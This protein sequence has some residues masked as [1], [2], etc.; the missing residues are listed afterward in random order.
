MSDE[1]PQDHLSEEHL[2]LARILERKRSASARS[3]V[4][5][6]LESGL[7][8][9]ETLRRIAEVDRKHVHP[10]RTS[11]PPTTTPKRSIDADAIGAVA[12]SRLG[13]PVYSQPDREA[14]RELQ[15]R[16]VR[17]K[18]SPNIGSFWDYLF[19]QSRT[20]R[21]FNRRTHLLKFGLFSLRPRIDPAAPARYRRFADTEIRELQRIVEPILAD[22]W[23]VLT[24]AE[25]NLIVVLGH[26]CAGLGR[27]S[28]P[29]PTGSRRSVLHEYA[30]IERDLLL[31]IHE[32]RDGSRMRSILD[33]YADAQVG[34]DVPNLRRAG[35]TITSILDTGSST[36]GVAALVLALNMVATGRYLDLSAITGTEGTELIPSDY[37]DC[38]VETGRRISAYLERMIG[39]V[40]LLTTRL[41][42]LRR[43]ET[44]VR[45]RNGESDE[46]EPIKAFA[47][48]TETEKN[49]LERV[50]QLSRRFG[51]YAGPILDG[52]TVVEGGSPVTAFSPECFGT[53]LDRINRVARRLEKARYEL[54]SFSLERFRRIHRQSERGTTFEREAVERIEEFASQMVRIGTKAA[55]CTEN[56]RATAGTADLLEPPLSPI[57]F[58][59]PFVAPS[60]ET[61]IAGKGP[62]AGESINNALNAIARIAFLTGR[63]LEESSVINELRESGALRAELEG[64]MAGIKRIASA[65]VYEAVRTT[66]IA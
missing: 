12:V 66:W 47:R 3:E 39:R 60:L 61:A 38:D 62:F 41:A 43:V 15:R 28:F 21:E 51:E 29:V 30:E 50:V 52:S 64:V 36:H 16:R 56:Y 13:I 26:L 49:V 24:K 27:H 20:I 57:V 2:L 17:V 59:R 34:G 19:R 31:L 10:G 11:I 33:R 5:T 42:E 35:A 65:E 6:I 53:D 23:T 40:T 63:Y 25:Y 14:R 54:N 18:A 55:R 48:W 37:F 46:Y 44:H 7:P 8:I 32:D 9:Q 45:G 58:S 1:Q 4:N 22:G